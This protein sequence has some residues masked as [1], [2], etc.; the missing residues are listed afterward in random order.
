MHAIE[1]ADSIAALRDLA[2]RRLPR[3]V[4]DFM[5]GGADEEISLSR[6][7]GDLR[8]VELTPRVL[9]D[10]SARDNASPILGRT[11]G[12]PL[13]IAPTGLAALGWPKADILLA[14]AAGRRGVPFVISTSSSVRIEDIAA[15]AG[16][17][18]LWFQ[19]YVYKDR[20]LVRSL[21][22]RASACGVEALVLTVDTP[23]LGWRR[24]DHANRFT[25]P[26]RPDLAMAVEFARCWRWTLDIARFGSP[27][28]QNFVEAG[29]SSDIVSLA[30]LMTR[31]M[32]ASVTWR[33]VAWLRDLWPGPLILK[34]VSSAA[35]AQEAVRQGIDAIWISNHGGRQLDGSPSTVSALPAIA[36]AVDGRA[37]IYLDGGIRSG[38]DI[39]KVLALGAQAAAVGRATLFGVSAGGE[40]GADRALSILNQELDRCLALMGLTSPMQLDRDCVRTPERRG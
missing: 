2:K 9:R 7:L 40:A 36:Q 34:G 16:Q 17:T 21:V 8:Q 26:L 24:R 25:V 37:E 11:G 39:A 13:I 31:N 27:K 6:N 23:V 35:D 5:D 4:F 38:G 15:E 19:V 33:E 29:Q 1:R 30:Q 10:V 22:E 18:R 28:M 20:D 14:R 3:P 32:D 12:L